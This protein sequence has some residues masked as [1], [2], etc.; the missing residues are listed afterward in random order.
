[1]I[2]GY[3]EYNTDERAGMGR[4]EEDNPCAARRLHLHFLGM[5]NSDSTHILRRDESFDHHATLPN[6]LTID[7]SLAVCFHFLQ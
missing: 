5:L 6:R 3:R 1:M 7:G 4:G 2:K